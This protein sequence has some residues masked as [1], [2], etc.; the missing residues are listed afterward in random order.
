MLDLR[1]LDFEMRKGPGVPLSGRYW[2][3][4]SFP[5]PPGRSMFMLISVTN[6][7]RRAMA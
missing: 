7:R 4:A 5:L 3:A 6:F 2:G 1:K